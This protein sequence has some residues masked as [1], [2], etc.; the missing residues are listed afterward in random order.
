MTQPTPQRLAN[1]SRSRFQLV[2]LSYARVEGDFGETAIRIEQNSVALALFDDRFTTND[3]AIE[4]ASLTLAVTNGFGVPAVLDSLNFQTE[5]NGAPE[6]VFETTMPNLEVS[7]AVGDVSGAVTSTWMVDE[8]NSNV[9]DFFSENE[10]G[11]EL[12]LFIRTNPN[13][14]APGEANFVDADGFVSADLHAEVPLSIRAGQVDFVDTLGC[15]PRHRRDGGTGFCG[16]AHHPA[17]RIPLRSGASGMVPG[18]GRRRGGQLGGRAPRPL[19]RAGFGSGRCAHGARG[20]PLRCDLSTGSVRT[21]CGPL[22]RWWSGHGAKRP[23]LR[24]ARLFRSGRNRNCGCNW[25][26]N[27]S[28][29]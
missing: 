29:E 14:L 19:C 2:D 1:P 21:G 28:P 20:I 16:I 10:V 3:L 11:M 7:P 27:S 18:C 17:Q 25:A 24:W 5:V 4:R 23:T 9:V 13:G 8:T 6:V 12:G 15:V 22:R 26:P